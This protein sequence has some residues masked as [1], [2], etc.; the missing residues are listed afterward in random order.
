MGHEYRQVVVSEFLILIELLD[1]RTH[2]GL[3]LLEHSDV[4]IELGIAELFII[5][6]LERQG[7]LV[8]RLMVEDDKVSA[9]VVIDLELGP[10]GFLDL[11]QE[12]AHQDDVVDRVPIEL[13]DVVRPRLGLYD[14]LDGHGGEDLGFLEVVIRIVVVVVHLHLVVGVSM[15]V[16]VRVAT[17]V[18]LVVLAA[19]LAVE[20]VGGVHCLARVHVLLIVETA[21]VVVVRIHKLLIY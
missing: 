7:N 21:L 11:L 9:R 8:F 15:G 3:I 10:H 18:H 17:M 2:Y 20:D 5:E 6:I 16:A 4:S 13:A 19:V 1:M 12:A 14:H